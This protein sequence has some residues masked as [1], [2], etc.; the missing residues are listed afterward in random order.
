LSPVE[1]RELPCH[2]SFREAEATE[3]QIGSATIRA[4]SVNHRGPTLGYRITDG[5][6]T[7]VYIPDHEPALGQR[8]ASASFDWVS[9][10]SLARDADLLIHDSQYTDGEYRDHIGWGH[11][12]LSDTMTFAERVGA[13]RLVLFHHEPLHDDAA[14]DSLGEEAH[15]LD[16]GRFEHVSLAR[17][18]ETIELPT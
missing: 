4:A 18:Q 16:G 1:V 9:G 10:A 2:P 6:A 11:S 17:E 15:A 5:D 14:L 7:V 13:R 8:L 12:G 3:W